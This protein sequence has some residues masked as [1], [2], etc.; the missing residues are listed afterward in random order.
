MSNISEIVN[1][2]LSKKPFLVF[3]LKDEIINISS[4][5]RKICEEKGIKNSDAV[6][7][8]IRRYVEKIFKQKKFEEAINKVVELLKKSTYSVHTGYVLGEL[9]NHNEKISVENMFFIN[10]G[11]ENLVVTDI[12]NIDFL[13]NPKK[14]LIIIEIHHPMEIKDIPGVIAYLYFK[15]F[16]QGINIEETFSCSDKTYIVVK[17]DFI[18]QSI[19]LLDE[20]LNKQD[21]NK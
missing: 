10:F 13:A 19:S 20:I 2:Y 4:L 9:K 8:A 11:K 21:L 5:A 7:M 14:D 18:Q 6:M 17:K 12:K 1:E 15:F 3:Y 16:E